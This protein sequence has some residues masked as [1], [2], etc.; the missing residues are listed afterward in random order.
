MRFLILVSVFLFCAKDLFANTYF[1]KTPTFES[2]PKHFI[3]NGKV[4]GM[5][6]D[7]LKEIEKIEPRL[8]FVGMDEQLSILEVE[9]QVIDGVSDVFLCNGETEKRKQKMR[10]VDI[11][12]FQAQSVLVARIEDKVKIK[13]LKELQN[14]YPNNLV[15]SWKGTE[16]NDWIL[17]KQNIM[18]DPGI[19]G[20]DN[21][22]R[23]FQ[24]LLTGRGRFL[25]VQKFNAIN[26]IKKLQIEDKVKILMPPLLESGRFIWLSKSLPPEVDVLIEKSLKKLSN[27][28]VLKKYA[29]KYNMN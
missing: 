18:T 13:S 5:C 6:I 9:Q 15:L 1:L 8:K 26:I 12:V 10:K 7:V 21:M 4:I 14:L 23:L 2:K 19:T 11:P 25:F 20:L 28:K 29:E 22:N 27:K 3:E 24:M 16:Q 17:S